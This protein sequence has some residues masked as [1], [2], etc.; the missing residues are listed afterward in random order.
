MK[1]ATGNKSNDFRN[2]AMK[3]KYD[4]LKTVIDT[5]EK[6]QKFKKLLL[7]FLNSLEVFLSPPNREIKQNAKVILDLDGIKQLKTVSMQNIHVEEIVNEVADI[8]WKL[9]SVVSFFYSYLIL[10]L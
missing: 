6:N 7:Y 2:R 5:I 8:I 10:L 1:K 4:T 9:I 3:Q